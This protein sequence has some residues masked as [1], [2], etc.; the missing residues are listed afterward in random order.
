MSL[1]AMVVK[2]LVWFDNS[3]VKIADNE[4]DAIDWMRVIPFIMMHLVCLL[5]FVVGCYVPQYSR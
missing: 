2:V 1:Q 5:V 4:V 3:N